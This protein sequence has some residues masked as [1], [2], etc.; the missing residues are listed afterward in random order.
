M[1]EA[2]AAVLSRRQVLGGMAAAALPAGAAERKDSSVSA[3]PLK[4][5][6]FSKHLQWLDWQ[7]AAATAKRI[8][9]DGV[10]LTVRPGGH[11][12]PEKVAE[13]L[14]K[15]VDAVRK[16]GLETPMITAGI[17]DTSSPHA[18]AILRT[19]SSLGIRH[20]R[21]GGFTYSK[22]KGIPEQL[23]ALKPRVQALADMNRHYG[24]CAMYHTHSGPGMVGAPQWDL[25]MLLH[26]FDSRLV[27]VNYDIG[28]ATVEGGYGGWLLSDRL[29]QPLMRGIALKDFR[30]SKDARGE[31]SPE[32]CPIGEGM[33]N[34]KRFF[35]LLKQAHFSGPV[36]LH[37][38]YKSLGGA[39]S[40][41][42]KLTLDGEEVVKAMRRDLDLVRGW[43]HEAQI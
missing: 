2:K 18:E 14:P 34:F 12:L 41:K 25:W 28:H 19:A 29:M 13:D 6:V 33:V 30:W 20:Y 36:Q 4:V 1:S 35:A 26:E 31:W 17:V 23:A 7:E 27:G 43:M 10:D 11:V 38:E 5:C 22:D 3:G 40:G 9:F 15:A 42:S 16:A 32:W 8:G 39:D 24:M 37:F 21:W